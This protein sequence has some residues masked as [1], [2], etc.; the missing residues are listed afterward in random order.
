[1]EIVQPTDIHIESGVTSLNTLTGAVTLS[2]GSNITLTTI[3]HNIQISSSGGSSGIT[4]LN[5]LTSASQTFAVGTSGTNFTISSSGT[6][7]TF[8]LPTASGT[9]RGALSST[10]WTTFNNKAQAGNKIS[11][12]VNNVG[13]IT[14]VTTDALTVFGDGNGTPLYISV[15][16]L[17]TADRTLGSTDIGKVFY[18]LGA[19]A[20]VTLTLADGITVGTGYKITLTYSEGETNDFTLK[21]PSGISFIYIGTDVTTTSGMV[22]INTVGSSVA[23]EVDNAG[24]Y[25]AT[26]MVGTLQITP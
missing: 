9:V 2:A 5:G 16:S 12:F 10:D 4:S 21:L 19:G 1:M 8:N 24:N 17:E 6:I 15:L 25:K 14:S 3:G 18:N 7:H 13:Y 26:N 20:P 23:L 11:I 22:T